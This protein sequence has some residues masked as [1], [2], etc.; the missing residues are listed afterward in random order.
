MNVPKPGKGKR[1]AAL[2][3]FP[4]KPEILVPYEKLGDRM[5]QLENYL[6]NLLSINIY[7]NHPSTVIMTLDY[8]AIIFILEIN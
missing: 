8:F 1:K 6:N 7:R 3:R 2:P 4:K 5:K